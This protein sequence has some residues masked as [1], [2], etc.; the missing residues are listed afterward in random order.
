ERNRGARGD[1]R[2]RRDKGCPTRTKRHDVAALGA[3][4]RENPRAELRRRR[5]C[6]RVVR[7]RR[8]SRAQHRDFVPTTFAVTKMLLERPH[9]VLVQCVERIWGSQLVNVVPLHG[10]P[11]GFA[12]LRS[13]RKRAR[14][15]NMRL[16]IV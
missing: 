8:G 1:S 7:E 4:G 2:G 15:E 14:P 16:L 9:L 10:S 3:R 6:R 5:Q 13:S 11:S 12:S